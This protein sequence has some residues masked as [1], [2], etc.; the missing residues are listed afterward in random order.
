M[1]RVAIIFT[2]FS[3]RR[4]ITKNLKVTRASLFKSKTKIMALL[5]T[6]ISRMLPFFFKALITFTFLLSFSSAFSQYLKIWEGYNSQNIK[7]TFY[8]IDSNEWIEKK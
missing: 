6:I 2:L 3:F 4:G 8:K 7:T 1:K 5:K